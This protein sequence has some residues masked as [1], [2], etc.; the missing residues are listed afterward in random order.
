MSVIYENM[1]MKALQEIEF[2][3]EE[4]TLELIRRGAWSEEMENAEELAE[5]VCAALELLERV[6][7]QLQDV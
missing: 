4:V 1:L 5:K 6:L 3:T 7:R 2:V